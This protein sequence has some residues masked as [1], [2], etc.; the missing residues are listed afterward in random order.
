MTEHD[1]M[2]ENEYNDILHILFFQSLQINVIQMSMIYNVTQNTCENNI[3]IYV[4]KQS[5]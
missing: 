2:Q 3:A 1:D 5:Q 4:Q